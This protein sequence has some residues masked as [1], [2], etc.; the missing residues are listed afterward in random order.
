MNETDCKAT[1]VGCIL[2]RGENFLQ[3]FRERL[4]GIFYKTFLDGHE[5]K[6]Y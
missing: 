2:P 1:S 5:Q 6:S 4:F 3:I